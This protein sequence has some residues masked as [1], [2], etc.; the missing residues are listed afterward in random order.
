M[1]YEI[2]IKYFLFS[3]QLENILIAAHIVIQYEKID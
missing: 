1:K 3:Q 2:E